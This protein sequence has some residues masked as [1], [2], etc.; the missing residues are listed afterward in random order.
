MKALFD[1]LLDD[2]ATFPPG[3]APMRVAVQR[4]VAHRQAWY[5]DFV[6]AFVCAAGRIDELAAYAGVTGTSIGVSVTVTAADPPVGDVAERVIR[7]RGLRLAAVE[8][9]A[10]RRPDPDG[11]AAM[12]VPAVPTYVEVPVAEVDDEI[13]ATLR[14]AGL[15]LKLRTGGTTADAFPS[16]ESLARA[17]RRAVSAGTRFKCT[18]GLHH[19]VRRRDPR[20]G[21]DH[22]GFCNVVLATHAA[23]HDADP[24]AC[25]DSR[26]PVSLAAQ[27]RGLSAGEVAGIRRLF[28]SFGTCSIEDPVVDIADMGLVRR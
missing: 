13:V 14:D 9:R 17:I 3:N 12:R 16:S 1:A 26:D 6:A 25:L 19:A 7:A 27:V 4:H 21:H 5:A 18:A 24:R 22:H 23:L 10:A 11:L 2:A 8:V 28:R 15:G 20:T